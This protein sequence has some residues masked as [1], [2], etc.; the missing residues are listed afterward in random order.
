LIS[1]KRAHLAVSATSN[2]GRSGKNN[3][4]RYGVTAFELEN[5]QRTQSV[6]AVIADG[7]GGHR[8]GEVAADLAV[9]TISQNVAEGDPNLPVDTLRSAV[10][11]ASQAIY[12]TAQKDPVLHGMG[13]TCACAWII[14]NQ[15]Y[16]A[17]AGDSRIYMIRGERILQL[18]TDHTWVQEA[19]DQGALR[20]DQ[21]RAHPNAHVIRR[22]LGSRQDVVPDMRLRNY[23]EENFFSELNQGTVLL[24]GD[25]LLISSDGLTD[26]VSDIEILGAIRNNDLKSSLDVLVGLANQRGGHDNITLIAMGMPTYGESVPALSPSRRRQ[27]ASLPC[28][29]VGLLLLAGAV[30]LGGIYWVLSGNDLQGNEPERTQ[31]SMQI[32]WFPPGARPGLQETISMVPSMELT[33]TPVPVVA[34]ETSAI[35]PSPALIGSPAGATLTPW[36]TNT[37]GAP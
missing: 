3:E 13:S 29:A 32:T 21:A 23:E 22:Y 19:I 10:V 5:E 8:A 6:L 18:T 4:D 11:Q 16:T 20:P 17:S 30:L 36:P 31:P 37:P 25:I 33:G 15:L 26:L 24:P 34:T 9:N 14:G 35:Q 12:Q 2:P 1:A 28:L 27:L 7:I